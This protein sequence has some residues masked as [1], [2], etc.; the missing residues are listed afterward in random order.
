MSRYINLPRHANGFDDQSCDR[1]LFKKIMSSFFEAFFN[2]T[3]NKVTATT[4]LSV[5]DFLIRELLLFSVGITEWKNA[6]RFD[7]LTGFCF[8]HSYTY[9]Y[10][11]KEKTKLALKFVG[12]NHVSRK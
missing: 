8:G 11:H 6:K 7:V 5:A 2:Y 9:N 12:Y 4:M 3:C 1:G 10:K